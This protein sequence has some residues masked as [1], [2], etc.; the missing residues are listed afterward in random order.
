MQRSAPADEWRRLAE[1]AHLYYV[2]NLLIEEVAERMFLSRSTVSRLLT[3]ARERGVVEFRV[4][5]SQNPASELGAALEARFR[6][7]ATVVPRSSPEEDPLDLVALAAAEFMGRHVEANLTIGVAWG[8]TVDVV[9]RHLDPVHA[10]N[11]DIVQL[12]GAVTIRDFGHSYAGRIL[13]RFARAYSASVAPLPMPAF[14]DEPATRAAM[15][16]ERGVQRTLTLRREAHLVIS[17]VGALDPQHP[18]HLTRSEYLDDSDWRELRRQGVVG[19]V[20][21]VFLRGDGSDDGIT[22]NDRSTGLPF[23]DLRRIPLRLL[24]V[25]GERKAPATRAA[26]LAGLATDLVVDEI[27]ARRILDT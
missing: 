19:N 24:V 2:E 10:P 12:N 26:L 9:S 27:T 5:H 20:G 21:S 17:S 1:A 16:R 23:G 14:F 3:R 11:C 22:I 13:E 8:T 7:R 6:V 4:H 15:F 18:S 25:A